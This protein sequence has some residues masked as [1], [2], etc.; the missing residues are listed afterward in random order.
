[1]HGARLARGWGAQPAL[2]VG[3]RRPRPGPCSSRRAGRASARVAWHS[4]RGSAGWAVRPRAAPPSAPPP[5]ARPMSAGRRAPARARG[6]ARWPAAR[7]PA[8]PRHSRGRPSGAGGCPKM[9]DGSAAAGQRRVPHHGLHL[10]A[11]A[12]RAPGHP[13]GPGRRGAPRRG[14]PRAP[15]G[16]LGSWRVALSPARAKTLA[17]PAR[18]ARTNFSC[19]QLWGRLVSC[20]GSMRQVF[21]PQCSRLDSF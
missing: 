15:A 2:A 8:A 9:R 6:P 12:Q 1:M 4:A 21:L 17:L 11:P 20:H 10:P 19:R 16:G 18:R 5:R 7:G 13:A 14:L 3:A